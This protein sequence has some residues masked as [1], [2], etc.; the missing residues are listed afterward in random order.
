MAKGMPMWKG[1]AKGMDPSGWDGKGKGW[2][3]GCRCG[4]VQRREWTHRDG[5]AKAKDGQRDADVEGCSEGNG[6][7]GMGWQ[8]QRMAKG[9]PMWKG[10]AKGMDPWGWDGKGKGWPKGCRCGRVQRREWTHG[11]GMAK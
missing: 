7:I 4:R 1:A 9:M 6:P 5:M 3:K 2:P 11:D 10:A 8:R